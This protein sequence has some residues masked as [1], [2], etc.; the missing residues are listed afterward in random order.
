MLEQP[1]CASD[2]SAALSHSLKAQHQ[3]T[4][5]HA[6]TIVNNLDMRDHHN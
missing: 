2:A 5:T 6:T 4:H 3:H 1:E